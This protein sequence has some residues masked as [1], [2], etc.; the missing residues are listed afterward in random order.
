M[1]KLRFGGDVMRENKINYIQ[2]FVGLVVYLFATY[3]YSSKAYCIPAILKGKQTL[4]VEKLMNLPFV[5]LGIFILTISI[6]AV[7]GIYLDKT[8]KSADK[9]FEYIAN[10]MIG[11]LVLPFTIIFSTLAIGIV[12]FAFM[13]GSLLTIGLFKL[14][15]VSIPIINESSKW[16]GYRFVDI[17]KSIFRLNTEEK[18]IFIQMIAFWTIMTYVFNPV[19]RMLK[20]KLNDLP[21]ITQALWVLNIFTIDVIRCITYLCAFCIYVNTYIYSDT[22]Q[23]TIV[24][25]SLMAYII[26]DVSIGII[27]SQIIRVLSKG[28]K[29]KY[30]FLKK[31]LWEIQDYKQKI[32]LF[33]NLISKDVNTTFNLYTLS[34]FIEEFQNR[35]VRKIKIMILSKIGIW[36]R[37]DGNESL[38]KYIKKYI[39]DEEI[40]SKLKKRKCI[41][42]KKSTYRQEKEKLKTHK[43]N[44][45]LKIVNNEDLIQDINC[46]E[47]G[48]IIQIYDLEK[49]NG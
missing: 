15:N 5:N 12:S 24:R 46:I 18:M 49:D 1:L 27:Y 44:L 36:N 20:Q 16:I 43:N 39:S 19:V 48:L 25:E 33:T 21:I 7:I 6:I 13:F 9:F 38:L 14:S 31:L 23:A 8:G 42:D 47:R 11:F 34:Q 37:F 29:S 3:I 26:I 30:I 45:P 35:K 32:L 4:D 10:Y 28:K 2:A 41:I 17:S 22:G 40:I